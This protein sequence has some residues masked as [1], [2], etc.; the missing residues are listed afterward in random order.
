VRNARLLVWAAGT[1]GPK[2]PKDKVFPFY[3][4]ETNFDANFK[5]NFY[6]TILFA[7][8]TVK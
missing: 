3:F 5:A 2:W 4:L 6:P 1:A 8:K 7:Q